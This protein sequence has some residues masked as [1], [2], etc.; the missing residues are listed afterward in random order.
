VFESQITHAIAPCGGRDAVLTSVP[1]HKAG[2]R[3]H[4]AHRR[5][6]VGVGKLLSADLPA[7]VQLQRAPPPTPLLSRTTLTIQFS[8]P[9]TYHNIT[10]LPALRLAS[11]AALPLRG[12]G[13]QALLQARHHAE[14]LSTSSRC[15]VGAVHSEQG[16]GGDA[17][18][19]RSQIRCVSPLLHTHSTA[20]NGQSESASSKATGALTFAAAAAIAGSSQWP[21]AHAD[22]STTVRLLR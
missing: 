19:T 2:S 5:G 20:H 16:C 13:T 12:A 10:M 7:A 8:R 21:E 6:A 18:T 11:L 15:V 9:L 3:E 17:T 22:A 1:L 14:A 4:A